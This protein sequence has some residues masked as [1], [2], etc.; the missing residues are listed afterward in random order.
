MSSIMFLIVCGA[1]RGCAGQLGQLL[2]LAEAR[3]PLT[4]RPVLGRPGTHLALMRDV[5]VDL[6]GRER[7]RERRGEARTCLISGVEELSKLTSNV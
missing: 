3:A 1:A 4:Q 2:G 7:G 6:Q 5:L